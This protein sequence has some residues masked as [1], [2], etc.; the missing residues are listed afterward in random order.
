MVKK[1]SL[2]EFQLQD[3]LLSQQHKPCQTSLEM[4][5]DKLLEM[6][7]TLEMFPMYLEMLSLTVL[8]LETDLEMVSWMDS[9][10]RTRIPIRVA[11]LKKPKW[12]KQMKMIDLSLRNIGKYM[13]YGTYVPLDTPS[14]SLYTLVQFW[15]TQKPFFEPISSESLKIL[16]MCGSK[17]PRFQWFF[18]MGKENGQIEEIENGKSEDEIEI[19]SDMPCKVEPTEVE[20]IQ[21]ISKV[22]H[23][24]VI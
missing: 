1:H 17:F 20:T 11:L 13:P 21:E 15:K 2:Q 10:V 24:W 14:I 23:S 16:P 9:D 6:L 3:F 19:E 7:E 12:R 18:R 4:P 8:H 5:N 22:S